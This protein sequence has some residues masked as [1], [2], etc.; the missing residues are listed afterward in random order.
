MLCKSRI[1]LTVK[2][3]FQVINNLTGLLSSTSLLF[4][5]LAHYRISTLIY[6]NPS[7][8]KFFYLRPVF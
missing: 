3:V 5:A 4:I 7:L 1:L 2:P 8:V 6:A